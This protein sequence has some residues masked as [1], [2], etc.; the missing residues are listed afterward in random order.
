[1]D[2]SLIAAKFTVAPL[3]PE[4]FGQHHRREWLEWRDL[5][6]S[7]A[8]DNRAA[9]RAFRIKEGMAVTP[10]GLAVTTGWHYHDCEMQ[11]LY[12]L[13][14]VLEYA[15]AG[16]SESYRFGPGTFVCIPGGTVHSELSVSE[17][18]SGIEITFPAEISTVPCE[19][20]PEW[21]DRCTQ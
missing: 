21:A 15:L 3:G 2:Q 20:P 4:S 17:D 18:H 13:T 10:Q 6:L 12:V 1:M 11:L 7:A 14:G 16:V 8:T 9:A 19:V 5:M